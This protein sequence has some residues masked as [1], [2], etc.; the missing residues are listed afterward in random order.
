MPQI[1][2]FI[3]WHNSGKTTLVG[4]IVAHL[5]EMGYRVGVVKS[6]KEE[7]IVF[8]T[9][10][11]DSY[12]HRQAGADSVLFAA[13]DQMVLMTKQGNRSLTS[14]AHRY[15]AD[16]DIVIGEGFKHAGHV[17]KIEVVRDPGQQLRNEVHGVI[18]V[19]T[20]L[21]MNLNI[22]SDCLFRLNESRKI[23]LFIE[24]RFLDDVRK[25]TE[26]TVL[27]VNDDK[28]PLKEFVQEALAG[29]VAGFVRSLK[30]AADIDK[31]ELRIK[32]DRDK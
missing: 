9:P 15:L 25:G 16:C 32:L 31:I 5:K 12:L 1:I 14:I 11:S 10:G 6:S 19:A 22:G 27:L 23:A 30:C 2:T 26:R 4:R 7:G 24:K 28:V 8:D 20:D 21:N 17:A 13:P 18:A 3:G 29:T